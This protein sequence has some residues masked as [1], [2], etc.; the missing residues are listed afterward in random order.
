MRTAAELIDEIRFNTNR[1]NK[2]RFTDASLLRLLNTAQRQI[3]RTI[4]LSNPV[5]QH[6]TEDHTFAYDSDTEIYALPAWVYTTNSVSTVFPMIGDSYLAPIVKMD[7]KERQYKSGYFVKGSNI[8]IP[9]GSVGA[10]TASIRVVLWRKLTELALVA[11]IPELPDACEDFLTLFVERKMHYIDSSEDIKNSGV[12]TSEEKTEI[13]GL[14]GDN[15]KDVSYPPVT[16]T[17]YFTY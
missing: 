10:S 17:S 7:E 2:N 14:F 3:Q 4:F 9:S 5:C 12:F 8:I 16:D 1:I 11:D 6:F 15:S 13:A